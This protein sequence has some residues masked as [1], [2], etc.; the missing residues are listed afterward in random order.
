MT[1]KHVSQRAINEV[2][3]DIFSAAETVK[4]F[5][6]P[7]YTSFEFVSNATEQIRLRRAKGTETSVSRMKLYKAIEAIRS[8]HSR[9]IRGPSGLREVGITHV[10]PPVW[11][12]IRLVPLNDLIDVP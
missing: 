9:Y 5:C 7:G 6:V 11:A 3:D 8:D 1:R 10:T 2:V 12:L 4:S